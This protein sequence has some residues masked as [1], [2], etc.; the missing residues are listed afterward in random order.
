MENQDKITYWQQLFKEY[1]ESE[2]SLSEFCKKKQVKR[3]T[4]HYWRKRIIE[5]NQERNDV[6]KSS[7]QEMA[8][9]KVPDI[10]TANHQV[11]SLPIEWNELKFS[12][13]SAEEAI[14]AATLIKE[15]RSIC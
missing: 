6:I 9:V 7:P 2:L 3:P 5:A 12:I 1:D 14:L 13:T 4:Y 15:L 8:F 11:A 10:T